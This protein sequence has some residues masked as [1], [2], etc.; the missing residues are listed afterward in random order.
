VIVEKE[1]EPERGQAYVPNLG[2]E[3][4][5]VVPSDGRVCHPAPPAERVSRFKKGVCVQMVR[6]RDLIVFEWGSD[7]PNSVFGAFG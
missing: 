6:H 1:G 4:L 3:V 2:D 5:D 7:E